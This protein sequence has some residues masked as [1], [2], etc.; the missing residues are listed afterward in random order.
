M[1]LILILSTPTATY[2]KSSERTE[3]ELMRQ[4]ILTQLEEQ[5]GMRFLPIY[6]DLLKENFLKVNGLTSILSTSSKSENFKRRT[7]I[8]MIR[9]K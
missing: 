3:Y 9:T 8:S 2:A 4:V 5:G 7:V 1:A 6:E